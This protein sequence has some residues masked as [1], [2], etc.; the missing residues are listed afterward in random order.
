MRVHVLT[1]LIC[2]RSCI[3]LILSRVDLHIL[4]LGRYPTLWVSWAAISGLALKKPWEGGMQASCSDKQRAAWACSCEVIESEV[5]HIENR[6]ETQLL[7]TKMVYM[8]H[9]LSRST[10]HISVFNI[11][12]LVV[13]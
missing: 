3:P 6:L 11:N 10:L 7:S 2:S 5:C 1:R 4:K 9:V 8:D 12:I 13:V